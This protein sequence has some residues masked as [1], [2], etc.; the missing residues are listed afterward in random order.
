L[1]RSELAQARKAIAIFA[2]ES[3]NRNWAFPEHHRAFRM[4]I[5]QVLR[6]ARREYLGPSEL[7]TDVR[8]HF[9]PDYDRHD[10]EDNAEPFWDP[11]MDTDN[12]PWSYA[13]SDVPV[14]VRPVLKDEMSVVDAA[15][16]LKLSQSY[17]HRLVRQG[18]LQHIRGKAVIT[19]AKD[20]V[21]RVRAVL[22][23]R[24]S[25]RA[26]RENLERAGKTRDAFRK[27]IYRT[28]GPRLKI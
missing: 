17:V 13:Q 15:A 2:V 23:S 8:Q 4:Y 12:G 16:Y 6:G 3:I 21:E 10:R 18:R 26:K 28:L 19:L 7:G 24:H 9:K 1:P 27:S 22:T 25:L 20:E 14:A 11:R 5:K